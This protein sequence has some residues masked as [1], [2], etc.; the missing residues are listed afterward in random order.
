M[1][2]ASYEFMTVFS[3]KFGVSMRWSWFL[4]YFRIGH[5]TKMRVQ[6]RYVYY[7]LDLDNNRTLSMPICQGYI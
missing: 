3:T 7:I 2:D 4:G 6:G 1:D 5:I